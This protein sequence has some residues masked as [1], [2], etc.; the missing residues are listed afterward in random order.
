MRGKGWKRKIVSMK[1]ILQ[2]ILRWL[3]RIF[4]EQKHGT[5]NNTILALDGIRGCAIIF[6]VIFH[7]NRTNHDNLWDWHTNPLA[8]SISTAGGGGVTLFFVLSGF[9]LFL[10]YAKA[11]LFARR[12]PL[13]RTFYLRRALRIMPGYYI[14]L[15]ALILLSAPQYLQPSH[16]TQLGLFL[17]LFMD[18]SQST[19][20]QLNGPYWTLAAEWQFYLIMPLLT[21]GI[22]LIV[23]RFQIKHR[24]Q[25]VTFCL[26]GIIAGGLLV[27]GLGFY[28]QENPTVT[29]LVARPVLNVILFFSF[30]IT[31]KYTEDFAVGMLASLCYVYAQSLP[32]EHRF[33]QMLHR[34]SLWLWGIGILILVFCAMWHF[35]STEPAWPFINPIMPIFDLLN[36]II[37]AFGYGACIIAILFGPVELRRL[38]VWQPL[39]WIGLISYSLY[40]WHL[41]LIVFFQTHVQQVLFPHLNHYIVYTLYWVWVLLI[42]VPFCMLYY[43]CVERPGILLGNRWRGRIEAKVLHPLKEDKQAFIV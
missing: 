6:V 28:F 5:Q 36:E 30:G 2:W 35:Q 14:S 41:P 31:G 18:S 43:A 26:V 15:F 38:F 25:A 3:N 24:L 39:R 1:H 19:F 33:V 22:L 29:I 11:L 10:P 13:A 4:E 16:F 9:L 37:M 21:L 34:F 7:V 40:I 42:I 20:R 8:S 27:R 12:W 17:T 32:D 23:R